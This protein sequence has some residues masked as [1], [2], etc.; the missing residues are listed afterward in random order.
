MIERGQASVLVDEVVHEIP[1]EAAPMAAVPAL[2]DSPER[3]INRELSWLH[4]NRRV[5]EESSNQAHPLP[6]ISNLGFTIAL[7]LART[8]DGKAM[9]ALIR[10]PNKIER[11]I[12]LPMADGAAAARVITIEHATGLFIG[13]LFPGYT[14]KGQ[15]AF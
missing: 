8:S 14:V 13:K 15:G 4:F 5:L 9:N 11:F 1:A 7:Q 10:M 6:F 12:R 3:F 2:T